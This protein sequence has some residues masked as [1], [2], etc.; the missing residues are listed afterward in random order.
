MFNY[1][2]MVQKKRHEPIFY[3]KRTIIVFI[4]IILD[5]FFYTK[6]EQ[7]VFIKGAIRTGVIPEEPQEPFRNHYLCLD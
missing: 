2:Q 6:K 5:L 1:V 4:N 3:T 7:P